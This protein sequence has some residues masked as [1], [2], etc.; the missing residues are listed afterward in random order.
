MNVKFSTALRKATMA[1][2]LVATAATG[3]MA[4]TAEA[5]P[6]WGGGY[7]GGWHRGG[8]GAGAVIA[9]GIVGAALGAAI[10]DSSRPRYYYPAE[11]GYGYAPPPP[12]PPPYYYGGY[13][14]PWAWHDGYYWDH[15][16]H[17]YYHRGW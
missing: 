8:G 13:Y 15:W 4:T 6:G 12:P 1:A 17:R 9:G 16:G 14:R 5:R 11:Y 3:L 2:A 7:R 10:V